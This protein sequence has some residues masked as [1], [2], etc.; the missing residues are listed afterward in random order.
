MGSGRGKHTIIFELNLSA[1]E[2]I[3]CLVLR[4]VTFTRTY[5][6]FALLPHRLLFP[7]L[8]AEHPSLLTCDT[9]PSWMTGRLWE[10]KRRWLPHPPIGIRFWQSWSASVTEG[11]LGIFHNGSLPFPFPE[12]Q[13]HLS[14]FLIYNTLSHPGALGIF[15]HAGFVSLYLQLCRYTWILNDT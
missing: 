5:K 11:P 1:S 3:L 14:L 9:I 13:G 10:L 7:S 8:T 2:I 6:G 15:F 12:L 4:A